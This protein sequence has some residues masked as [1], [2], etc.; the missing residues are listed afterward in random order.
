MTA[1]PAQPTGAS[2]PY[3]IPGSPGDLSPPPGVP[4]PAPGGPRPDLAAAAAHVFV[5]DLGV[6]VLDDGDAHHLAHV[7]RLEAGEVVSASDG[8]GRWRRCRFEPAGGGPAPATLVPV[9]PVVLEERAEPPI[10]VAFALV[11]G[12]RPEWVVQKLTEIGVDTI[13]PLVTE[14]TVV[15][16]PAGRADRH[17]GRLRRVAREA[18]MQSRRARL[19]E[20]GRLTTFAD[21][22]AAGDV[23]ARGCLARPGGDPPSLDRPVVLVG[24]EGG[25]SAGEGASGLPWVDLGRTVLRAETAALAAGVLLCALRA[26]LVASPG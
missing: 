23:A 17:L 13:L 8:A 24:P 3:S 16:W 15:R 10:T 2:A 5:A 21:L 22:L 1:G 25:W 20:V 11:K 9:G 26:G 12:Q 4:A 6:P 19:P 14:R 7:L 18:A